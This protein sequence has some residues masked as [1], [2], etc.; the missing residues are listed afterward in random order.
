M[1]TMGEMV[2]P[3]TPPRGYSPPGSAGWSQGSEIGSDIL[4]A[5]S[6]PAGATATLAA[7]QHARQ[8]QPQRREGQEE[9]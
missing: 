2:I 6:S 9:V 1:S 4:S 5:H 8:A 3:S 7:Q